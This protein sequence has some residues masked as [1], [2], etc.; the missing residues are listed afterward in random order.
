MVIYINGIEINLDQNVSLSKLLKS[1]FAQPQSSYAVALNNEFIPK[2]RYK[3]I[4]IKEG[5]KVEVVTAKPGG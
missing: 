4:I 1:N 3:D 2:S 5:D